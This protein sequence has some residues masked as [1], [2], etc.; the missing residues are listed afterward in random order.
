M[1]INPKDRVNV[2]EAYT[3][4]LEPMQS[5]GTRYDVTRQAVYKVLC[6]AGID[7]SKGNRGKLTVSCSACGAEIIRH[8][9]RIRKQKNLFCDDSCYFAYLAAGN[10]S[11]PYVQNRQ[12]QRIARAKVAELFGLESG[13]VVHHEDRNTL[14]N[15]LD[16]LRIFRNQGDHV[17]YHRDLEVSPVWSGEGLTELSRS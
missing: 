2:I 13:N 9:F 17:R 15:M 5:I 3:V 1:K 4:G 16:N 14:N 7:T 6:R 11:G 12:G 8:R 10:G